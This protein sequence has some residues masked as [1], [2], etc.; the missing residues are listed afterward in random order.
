MGNKRKYLVYTIFMFSVIYGV[1]FHFFQDDNQ[2]ETNPPSTTPIAVQSVNN[3]V[4]NINITNDQVSH[5]AVI[6][7]S[8]PPDKWGKDPFLAHNAGEIVYNKHAESKTAGEPRLTG[9][10]YHKDRAS[11]AIINNKVLQ[12]SDKVDGWQI[13]SI[14]NEYVLI[15]KSGVTK[16]LMMGETL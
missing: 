11:F 14:Y 15:S 7:W 8:L 12:V 16:T 2:M 9:I 3:E 13:M 10:S 5:S 4:N 1:W 6:E